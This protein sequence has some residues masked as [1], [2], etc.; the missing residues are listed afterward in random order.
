M[1]CFLLIDIRQIMGL[2]PPPPG[3]LVD[4]G[5]GSGWTTAMFA[6]SGYETLGVDIAPAG[7]DLARH[8]FGETGAQ[9]EVHDF[10]KLP[11]NNQFDVAVIYDCLHHADNPQAVIQAT[12]RALRSGGEVVIVEP[13][14]GHHDSPTSQWARENHGTTEN[15]MSPAVVI[16]LL[17]IAGFSSIRTLP[18]A[19]F[20]VAEKNGTGG[21]MR[22]LRP[23]VGATLASFVKTVKNSLFIRNN[24]VVWAKK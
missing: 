6:K 3:R 1:Q 12:C 18:R 11:F 5:C 4:L 9:F 16:P 22:F 7:I 20:Q 2:I 23:F 10:E 24:G 14:R 17:R 15:D 8:T 21:I 19:Q 13:G